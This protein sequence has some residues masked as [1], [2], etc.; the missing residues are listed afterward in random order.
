[1]IDALPA[2]T[3]IRKVNRRAAR[4]AS[5]NLLW[6]N[7]PFHVQVNSHSPIATEQQRVQADT[8]IQW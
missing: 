4:D 2:E 7:Q 8:I 3:R 6:L 1:M 5:A